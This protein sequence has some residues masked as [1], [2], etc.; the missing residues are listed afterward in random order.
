MLCHSLGM[1]NFFLCHTLLLLPWIHCPACKLEVRG[2]AKRAINSG[3]CT[4]KTLTI[5]MHT[6]HRC[7]AR[8]SLPVVPDPNPTPPNIS[9]L[10]LHDTAATF[11]K[12]CGSYWI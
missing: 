1:K 11:K 6:M 9:P 7:H 12:N 2:I 10:E 4:I 3:K 5:L 8:P